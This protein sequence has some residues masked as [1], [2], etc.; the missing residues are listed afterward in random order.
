MRQVANLVWVMLPFVVILM[1]Q[2][3][4]LV[5]VM[6]P[7]VVILMRQ[8]ANLVWVMLPFLMRQVANLVWVML[9][10]V[11]M[12][13]MGAPKVRVK[14]LVRKPASLDWQGRYPYKEGANTI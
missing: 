14:N 9:P 6:L 10:F 5:W 11:V 7:F 4:N 3:A 13:L 2:V 1:R 12:V 8:V